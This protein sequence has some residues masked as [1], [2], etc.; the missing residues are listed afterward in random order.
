M[1]VL[2]GWARRRRIQILAATVA[3]VVAGGILLGVD[4]TGSSRAPSHPSTAAGSGSTGGDVSDNGS[5]ATGSAGAAAPG[6]TSTTVAPLKVPVICTVVSGNLNTA[7]TLRDCSQLQATGGSGTFPGLVL[8]RSGSGTVSWN[9]T[10][11]TTFVYVSS[12]PAG[13]RRKC[14]GDDTET[15]LK[16]SVTATAPIGA[17]N[18]GV[19]G[20]VHAKL[21]VDPSLDVTLAPG[22]A[23]QL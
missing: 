4:L 7:I 9:G 3:L 5:G 8:T 14:A 20:A 22:R 21:C 1:V 18:A 13:Q 6:A 10:G 17:G 16:G 23:F 2:P 19:K 12:H 15:T 11:T